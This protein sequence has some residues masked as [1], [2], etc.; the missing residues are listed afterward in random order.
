M[1]GFPPGHR[2]YPVARLNKILCFWFQGHRRKVRPLVDEFLSLGV[3]PETGAVLRLLR[4]SLG[5]RKGPAVVLGEEGMAL[6]LEIVLR[7]LDLEKKELVLALLACLSGE[8]RRKYAR[9]IGE[10]FHRYGYPEEAEQ[11]LRLDLEA[12]GPNAATLYLLGEL[13]ERQGAHLEAQDYFRAAL[14]MEPEEP[15]HYVK[16]IGVYEAMR[17]EIWRKAAEKYPAAFR[18]ADAPP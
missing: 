14:A 13:K 10:L 2:L 4:D 17:R 15:R 8:C 5:R 11:Y 3:S 16:L 7:A 6:L 9:A 1:D 18:E 12:H